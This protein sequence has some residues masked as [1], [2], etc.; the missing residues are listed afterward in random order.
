MIAILFT[1][2]SNWLEQSERRRIGLYLGSATNHAEL[3]RR[4]RSL[5]KSPL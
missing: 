4:I 3:E 2:L 1:T 5:D